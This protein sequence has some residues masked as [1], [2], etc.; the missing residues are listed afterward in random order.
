VCEQKREEP[1]LVKEKESPSTKQSGAGG[2]NND[3]RK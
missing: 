2:S 1:Y 3:S